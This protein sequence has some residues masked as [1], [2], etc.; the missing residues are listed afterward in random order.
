MLVGASLAP[1]APG[2]CPSLPGTEV[3]PWWSSSLMPGSSSSAAHGD[4]VGRRSFSQMFFLGVPHFVHT[5]NSLPLE[6]C[7]QWGNGGASN[8]GLWPKTPTLFWRRQR[9]EVEG[10]MKWSPEALS[11]VGDPGAASSPPPVSVTWNRFCSLL[12]FV[13]EICSSHDMEEEGGTRSAAQ[14]DAP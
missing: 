14:G 12:R 13:A 2:L 1:L 11:G 7:S 9:R 5:R 4:M 8:G 10:W 3:N 6:S